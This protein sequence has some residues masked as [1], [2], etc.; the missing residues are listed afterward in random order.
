MPLYMEGHPTNENVIGDLEQEYLVRD[1]YD[2][3]NDPTGKSK[4]NEIYDR[5]FKSIPL[6]EGK[7]VTLKDY[8]A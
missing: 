8:F 1:I 7:K 3:I 5:F 6:F 2:A 4:V